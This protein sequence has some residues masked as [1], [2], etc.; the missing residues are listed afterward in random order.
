VPLSVVELLWGLD[1]MDTQHT[2]TRVADFALLDFDPRREI[3]RLHDEIRLYRGRTLSNEAVLH[4]KLVDRPGNPSVT[5]LAAHAARSFKRVRPL[6]RV[7]SPWAISLRA[8]EERCT[9]EDVVLKFRSVSSKLII[10]PKS[11]Q[12][13]RHDSDAVGCSSEPTGGFLAQV[14]R[15][16]LKRP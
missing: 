13:E 11:T 5:G 14:Y 1:N 10:S 6:A 4:A 8:L 12:Q 16:R 3:V 7:N 9:Y 2:A 15:L